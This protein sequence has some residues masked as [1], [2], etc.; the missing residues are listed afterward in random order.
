MCDSAAAWA[1]GL[2]MALAMDGLW[3]SPWLLWLKQWLNLRRE[4]VRWWYCRPFSCCRA[5]AEAVVMGCWEAGLFGVEMWGVAGYGLLG[6]K[7]DTY[8]DSNV[9]SILGLLGDKKLGSCCG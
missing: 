7:Y 4:P 3:L 9:A 2:A 8:A 6:D 5:A 1:M